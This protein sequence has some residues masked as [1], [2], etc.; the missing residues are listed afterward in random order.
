MKRQ[1]LALNTLWWIL[2]SIVALIVIATVYKH[3]RSQAVPVPKDVLLSVLQPG[4]Y[5]GTGKYS[6]TEF[7]PNGL[8]VKLKLDVRQ[9]GSGLDYSVE[10]IAFDAKTGA[11][12][13]EG[14]R[15]GDFSYKP[16]H[17]DDLFRNTAS[18]IDGKLVS[19]SHGHVTSASSTHMTIVS[20]GTWHLS[21]HQHDIVVEAVRD[22]DKLRVTH[23][24]DSIIPFVNHSTL[25]EEYTML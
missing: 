5:V 13:Y 12:A 1:T 21:P 11:Q 6:A 20:S 16:N 14:V 7:Y 23:H 2:L 3:Y 22:G 4:T 9:T 24:N 19:S 10:I 8:D 15:T 25:I 18:Y 17:G